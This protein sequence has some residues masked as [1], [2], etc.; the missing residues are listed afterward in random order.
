MTTYVYIAQ[1]LDGFIADKN[2]DLEWLNDIPNPDNSDFGF[3]DFINRI[4]GIVMGRN[5]FEK[6]DSFNMWPY[7][8]HV[9]VISTT[10]KELS[11]MYD[12]KASLLN[13]PPSQIVRTLE[14]EGMQN[15]YIDGGSLFQISPLSCEESGNT[16]W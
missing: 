14:N 16:C 1:S 12:G 9:Y 3:S 8:K 6:V 15:L 13:L 11:D 2:G 4:D 7:T 5:T 10:L